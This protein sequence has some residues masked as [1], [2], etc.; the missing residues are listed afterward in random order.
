VEPIK[1]IAVPIARKRAA[2][3]PRRAGHPSPPPDSAVGGMVGPGR[4]SL[5]PVAAAPH[6]KYRV[7]E[8]VMMRGGG[9][10]WARAETMCRVV[11]LLPHEGGPLR[12]RV[13]SDLESFE[14]VV[15]EIDLDAVRS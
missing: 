12:Y 1:S 5:S 8:R 7:G 3:K 10:A 15:E 9:R 11:S 14:R 13:R 6:H 2:G 4:R